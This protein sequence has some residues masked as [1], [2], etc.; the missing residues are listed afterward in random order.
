V[1]T[2]ENMPYDGSVKLNEVV[3]AIIKTASPMPHD[4]YKQLRANGGAILNDETSNITVGACMI[5]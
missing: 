2:L 5:Q 3:K 1:N 4:S